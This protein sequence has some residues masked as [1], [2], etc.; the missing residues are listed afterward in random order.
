MTQKCDCVAFNKSAQAFNA[1]TVINRKPEK[2]H[3][4]YGLADL[5]FQGLLVGTLFPRHGPPS[6]P[7]WMVLVQRCPDDQ[8][9]N[10]AAM[11]PAARFFRPFM[12]RKAFPER[13]PR[14]CRQRVR[15]DTHNARTRAAATSI[16]PFFHKE[17]NAAR[18]PGHT[19]I[20]RRQQPPSAGFGFK[21]V[22]RII[23]S[24]QIF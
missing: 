22:Q 19:A 24:D 20:A 3:G 15:A 4:A 13:G 23:E 21:T 6:S 7:C 9:E 14:S 12:L 5:L 2:R 1:G 18:R 10:R 8:P 11:I 16:F 17:I